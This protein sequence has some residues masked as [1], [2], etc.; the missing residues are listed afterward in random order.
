V[1]VGVAFVGYEVDL[2]G[3][4]SQRRVNRGLEEWS[5]YFAEELL[6]V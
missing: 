3:G 5:A 6:L 1:V 2:R 4:F